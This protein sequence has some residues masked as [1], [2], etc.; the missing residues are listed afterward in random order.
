MSQKIFGCPEGFPLWQAGG[1]TNI[2]RSQKC[3]YPAFACS[4]SRRVAIEK[5]TQQRS[6]QPAPPFLRDKRNLFVTRIHPKSAGR[7]NIISFW[8]K[9]RKSEVEARKTE[10][11]KRIYLTPRNQPIESCSQEIA[12]KRPKN[13]LFF[14]LLKTALMREFLV[15][16]VRGGREGTTT[17]IVGGKLGSVFDKAKNGFLLSK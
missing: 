7:F 3:T 10:V 12:E 17:G 14:P 9:E 6:T 15:Q 4:L 13:I 5:R 1:V 11:E 16:L 2:K 8:Q